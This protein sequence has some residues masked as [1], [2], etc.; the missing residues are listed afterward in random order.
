MNEPAA[1]DDAEAT[2]K[3]RSRFAFLLR[4]WFLVALTICTVLVAIPLGYRSSR[5]I[6]VPPIAEIV[7]RET[8]GRIDIEP[9]QN[10]FTFYKRAWKLIPSGFDSEVVDEAVDLLET[11]GWD[12]VSPE[13]RN[14][15]D[16]CEET[17]AE[18]KRGTDLERGLRVQVADLDWMN[19]MDSTSAEILYRLARLSSAQALHEG[20]SEEAWQWLRA[21]L[22]FSRHLGNPGFAYDRFLG[23]SYH[24]KAGES[25]AKWA[26][27]DDVSAE[28]LEAALIEVRDIDRLTVSNSQGLKSSYLVTMRVLSTGDWLDVSRSHS[29]A[30][31]LPDQL[32]GPY[33]FV[34]AEPEVSRM[35]LRH[36]Y[37]NLL[38]QC[39][40]PRWER[41]LAA[42]AT[43]LFQP[44]GTESPELLDPAM[45]VYLQQRSELANVL[46]PSV[47]F[48]D[49]FDSERSR[50][51]ALELCLSVE[52]FRRHHGRYPETL[53]ALVPEFVDEVPRDVFGPT[54]ADRMLMIRRETELLDEPS[55]EP[56]PPAGLIIYSRGGNGIDD[57][58]AI[59]LLN[60]VG[61]RIPL[62]QAK[63][64]VE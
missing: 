43:G 20:R 47:S 17:L 50:Q 51:I 36:C 40:R 52:L 49:Y 54:S 16:Q 23:V 34:T 61:L 27:H 48:C 38:S 57:A 59:E 14:A 30:S 64:K 5:L 3:P 21:V 56:P 25:I 32:L 29:V 37:A 24:A 19:S 10:A 15:L 9:E 33:F 41:S 1:I 4:P 28:Q 46:S 45:L 58:G 35:L 31:D 63:A 42:S 26:A 2:L 44:T 55:E 22:R 13:A 39:D 60:D 7:D 11:E 6:A 12:K 18:W 8:E 62:P 53:E